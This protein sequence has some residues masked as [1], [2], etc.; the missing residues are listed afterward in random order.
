MPSISR[1]LGRPSYYLDTSTL[2]YAFRGGAADFASPH[3]DPVFA[4]LRRIVEAIAARDNLCVST[5]H[6]MELA[7]QPDRRAA[8][9]TAR[10]LDSLDVVWT[11]SVEQVSNAEYEVAVEEAVGAVPSAP[12]SVFSESLLG[13]FSAL[14]PLQVSEALRDGRALQAVFDA[15]RSH[16]AKREREAMLEMQ[17]HLY[18]DRHD[19]PITAALT[20]E[21]K[22]RI[23]RMKVR[24]GLK[25][26]LV[27]AVERLRWRHLPAFHAA[28]RAT[29]S[30]AE[31]AV[32][33]VLGNL[34]KFP[35]L[36]VALELTSHHAEVAARRTPGSRKANA[37]ASSFYDWAHALVGG[38]YCDTFV[39]DKL[40][41]D[42]MP[43]VRAA[44]G[45]AAP[46]VFEGGRAHAFLRDLASA[47][48]PP[49]TE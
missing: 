35:T 36:S 43:N 44:L 15:A 23:T 11:L 3:D 12:V 2:S 10:W 41:R 31:R 34:V 21:D 33:Y 46:L 7:Q 47:P 40:V 24:Q 20:P 8:E 17:R 37:L 25:R 1:R 48:R 38:G 6:I 26:E 13:V 45:L 19:D 16:G 4:E 18:F 39:C 5:M 9:A 30:A 42:G 27:N 32:D 49:S 29:D 28:W 22:R 14:T